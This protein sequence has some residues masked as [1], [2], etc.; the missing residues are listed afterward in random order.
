MTFF[1]GAT[2]ADVDSLDVRIDALE[3]ALTRG[4]LPV[5]DVTDPVYGGVMNATTNAQRLQNIAALKAAYNA[6]WNAGG[7]IILFPRGVFDIG[8][9][10]GSDHS[11]ELKTSTPN[12]IQFMGVGRRASFIKL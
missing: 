12:T 5:F 1:P 10:T 11:L 3:A 4:A 2:K 7:G 8:A 6:A 9:T